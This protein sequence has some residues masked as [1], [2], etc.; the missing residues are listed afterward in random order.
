MA[1]RDGLPTPGSLIESCM[2]ATLEL[3]K[4]LR[5]CR[6]GQCSV[7]LLFISASLS[8]SIS[9]HLILQSPLSTS[10]VSS[11]LQCPACLLAGSRDHEQMYNPTAEARA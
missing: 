10:P 6:G 7:H 2:G 4:G 11:M 8:S 1:E 3:G 9:S 5:V